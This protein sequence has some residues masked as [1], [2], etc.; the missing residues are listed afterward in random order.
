[1]KINEVADLLEKDP[2]KVLEG[3]EG[4]MSRDL[5]FQAVYF[6]AATEARR[7]TLQRLTDLERRVDELEQRG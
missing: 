2:V 5:S 4:Q 7:R 6:A 1:M 3:R